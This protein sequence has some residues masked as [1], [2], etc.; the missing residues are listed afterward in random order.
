MSP[1]FFVLV[2]SAAVPVTAPSAPAPA[3][4]SVTAEDQ[5]EF[6]R[7]LQADKSATDGPEISSSPAL[8]ANAF[9]PDMGVVVDTALARFSDAPAQLGEHDP[10]RNGFT[11]QQLEL[12]LRSNID[13][14][15]RLESFIVFRDE[16]E[17]E[18]AVAAT[19]ALPASLQLRAG[20]FLNRFGRIN[21]THLHAWDFAD[22][23]LIIGKFFGGDGNRGLGVEPSVLLPLPWYAELV[24]SV[25]QP[26]G[27]A[28]NRS[29]LRADEGA[30][31]RLS[32]M[33]SMGALKQ[34]WSLSE[35]LGLFAGISAAQ[36]PGP[37]PDDR[38]QLAGGDVY[39]RWRP[40]TRASLEQMAISVQAEW[41]AR[42]RL[43]SGAEL[44]DDGGYAQ[45]S[46]HY[47]RNWAAA[48]RAETV[49]GLAFDPLDPAW[50]DA[51]VR[52]AAQISYSPTE[53]SRIRLQENRDR[54]PGRSEP[55]WGTFLTLEVT[56][57]AHG[58]HAY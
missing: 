47:D 41:M 40:V 6:E 57:G 45:L 21:A 11:L 28:A 23:P 7:A 14:Y 3:T 35:D 54:I 38:S 48:A 8:G 56:A 25:M 44:R 26:E 10:S 4:D 39:L 2:L 17:I 53:F 37:D 55:L 49:S 9:N 5:A 33:L 34:F 27:D 42:R 18:E 30:P 43:W 58:A 24:V 20:K 31:N 29:F 15:F 16:V 46:Y 36:G 19:T 1:I 32:H 51:R 50:T 22:Q 13:P 12:S 52:H